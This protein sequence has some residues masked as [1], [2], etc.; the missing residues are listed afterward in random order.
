MH[1][2]ESRFKIYIWT[3]LVGI[4]LHWWVPR[5]PVLAVRCSIADDD[6]VAAAAVVRKDL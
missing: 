5:C 4:L 2:I 1:G 6:E 3:E